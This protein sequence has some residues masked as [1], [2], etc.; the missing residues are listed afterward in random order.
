MAPARSKTV[1][2]AL[3]ILVALIALCVDLPHLVASS[4]I[5][6]LYPGDVGIEAHPDVIFVERF[7]E[8]SLG[9]VFARWTDVLNGSAMSLSADVPT[10]SVGS[11]SLN[12]PWQGGGLNNGGHLYKQLSPLDDTL[13]VRYYIKYPTSG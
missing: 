8:S 7:E 6:A 10:A 11:K 4:V 12:I 13:Y 9:T 5:A 1:S 2:A 3:S